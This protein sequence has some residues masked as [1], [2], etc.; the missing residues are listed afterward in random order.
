MMKIEEKRNSLLKDFKKSLRELRLI[1]QID[2]LEDV[3]RKI[4]EINMNNTKEKNAQRL[5]K[6]RKKSSL[7]KEIA[8]KKEQTD[9]NKS[10]MKWLDT[11]QDDHDFVE[12]D[13]RE[14]PQLEV[15]NNKKKISKE[16]PPPSEPLNIDNLLTSYKNAEWK[17]EPLP[18]LIVFSDEEE[19]GE[20]G[21]ISDNNENLNNSLDQE[22]K[23]LE[24]EKKVSTIKEM[25]KGTIGNDIA[26]MDENN[27]EEVEV[28]EEENK[29]AIVPL[30]MVGIEILMK[31]YFAHFSSVTQWS[32]WP[33]GLWRTGEKSESN[34]GQKKQEKKQTRAPSVGRQS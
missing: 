11:L 25:L 15:E 20:E 4:K 33:C 28:L 3:I 18:P 10:V 5:I 30:M 22:S 12:A 17:D 23:D 21:K 31:Y 34:F 6:H 24:I 14:T 29:V 7:K 13:R 19:D 1:H 26:G 8:S 16:P 2:L 27:A 32:K 9:A